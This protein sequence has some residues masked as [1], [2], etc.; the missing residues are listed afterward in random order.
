MNV[1]VIFGFIV[2]GAGVI[3]LFYG[4]NASKALVEQ[5]SNSFLGRFSDSTTWYMIGGSVAAVA[6]ILMV[7]S[8][9]RGK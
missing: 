9:F 3:A 5:V 7:I 8:G 1:R 6:G 2:L 4:L